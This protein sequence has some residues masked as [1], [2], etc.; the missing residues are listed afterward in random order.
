MVEDAHRHG[1]RAACYTV[2]TGPQL[3]RALSARV[4]AVITDDPAGMIARLHR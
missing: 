3:R 1:M 4:D 2:N